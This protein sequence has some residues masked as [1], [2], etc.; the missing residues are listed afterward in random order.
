MR[1]RA[2]RQGGFT[3][4]E[5]LVVI[6]IIGIL[7]GLL[8][9][10]LLGA[11]NQARVAA[12]RAMLEALHG[13]LENYQSR[14][15]DYPPSSLAAFRIGQPNDTN[16][17]IESAT[18]CLATTVGGR[19]PI[20]NFREDTYGNT[21]KDYLAGNPTKWYFGDSQLREICDDWGNP[22]VYFH[23]RDYLKPDAASKYVIN[24]K[25]QVC[26]PQRG[27]ATAAFHNPYKYQIWSVGADGVNQ[28]GGDGDIP[29]W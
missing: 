4:V 11:K 8:I 5:V 14:F 2:A 28:N 12:T 20:E 21:D 17:G 24:G 19:P 7:A 26:R 22:I 9:P 13:A 23:H 3:L 29:G 1:P 18:A 10:T 16:V 6:A 27:G 15:G 25:P